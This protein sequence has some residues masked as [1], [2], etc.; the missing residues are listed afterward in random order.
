MVTKSD[1]YHD[2]K[3][4]GTV[5]SPQI[6]DHTWLSFFSEVP[7]SG[8][9]VETRAVGKPASSYFRDMPYNVGIRID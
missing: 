1:L 2:S 4:F 3:D 8:A 6:R 9:L 5:Q 7:L